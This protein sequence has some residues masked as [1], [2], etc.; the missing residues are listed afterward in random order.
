MLKKNFFTFSRI[1]QP[2]L[3]KRQASVQLK[4]WLHTNLTILVTRFSRLCLPAWQ[5]TAAAM[6]EAKDLGDFKF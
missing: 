6:G 4:K 5:D 3:S 1:E 2:K